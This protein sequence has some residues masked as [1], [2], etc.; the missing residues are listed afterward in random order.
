MR[1]CVWVR[2]RVDFSS[3]VLSRREREGR[4]IRWSSPLYW[5]QQWQLSERNFVPVIQRVERLLLFCTCNQFW[6]EQINQQVH[7]SCPSQRSISLSLNFEERTEG[8]QEHVRLIGC[9]SKHQDYVDIFGIEMCVYLC[10]LF[11]IIEWALTISKNLQLLNDCSIKYALTSSVV[12]EIF[13][14]RLM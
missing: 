12:L 9:V 2:A 8:N 5:Y 14:F 13:L 1:I 11:E 10:T 3:I 6:V 4:I 7:V